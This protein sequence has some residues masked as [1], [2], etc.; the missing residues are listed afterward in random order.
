MN[1]LHPFPI[2]R[3]AAELLV[4]KVGKFPPSYLGVP[5]HWSK[6]SSNFLHLEFPSKLAITILIDQKG[7]EK[8]DAITRP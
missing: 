8:G 2:Q 5:L 3:G 6:P 4:C 1:L 7:I